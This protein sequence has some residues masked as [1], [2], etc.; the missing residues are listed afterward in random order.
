MT[1][2][3]AGTRVSHP[4]YGAGIE[5]LLEASVMATFGRKADIRRSLV[6]ATLNPNPTLAVWHALLDTHQEKPHW[7]CR[8]ASRVPS[9]RR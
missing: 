8:N 9:P 6:D 5:T 1:G 4:P 3:P 2:A 7:A